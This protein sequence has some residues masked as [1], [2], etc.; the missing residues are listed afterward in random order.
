MVLSRECTA[1]GGLLH[2]PRF[3][4]EDSDEEDSDHDAPDHEPLVDF[5]EYARR[6]PRNDL[7]EVG[8]MD[9]LSGGKQTACTTGP[10]ISTMRF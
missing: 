6:C 4:E 2:R 5:E 8:L 3:N 9:D 7:A 10:H 1:F